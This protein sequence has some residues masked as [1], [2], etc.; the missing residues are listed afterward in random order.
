MTYRY[1]TTRGRTWLFALLLPFCFLVN[2]LSAQTPHITSFSPT[3]GTTGSIVQIHG[4]AFTGVDAVTFGK[5]IAGSFIVHSDT[6]ITAHVGGGNSGYVAVYSPK[7]YDSLAGFVFVSRADRPHILSFTPDSGRTGTVV[8][9]TGTHFTGTTAVRFGVTT[10]AAFTVIADT[11]IEATVGR[12]SSGVVTVT[13]PVATAFL[14]GFRYIATTV[15]THISFFSPTSGTMGTTVQIHGV[16]FTGTTFVGF[17][18]V[19]A[20]SFTVAAD[21]L[22]SAVVGGGASGAVVVSGARGTDS[23]A[24]FTYTLPVSDT[25][26][27]ISFTPDSGSRGTVVTINGIHFIGATSV[28]FGG[29]PATSFTVISDSVVDATVGL[30]ASGFVTVAN[31]AGNDSLAGFT[32]TPPAAPTHINYFNPT[33][34]TTGTTVFIHGV[35]FTGTTF[36]GFGGVSA[37]SFTVT[38]D[39]LIS[40]VVGGGASG[41]VVVSGSRGSDSLAGF[42]YTP[43]VSDT[44][45]I[46]SFT[47]D[48]GTTGT[49]VTINGTHF[50]GVSAVSFGGT[51]ASSFTVISD[52]V[53]DATVGNGSSG[54]VAMANSAGSDSLAGFVFVDSTGSTDS[55]PSA[56][57]LL[58][59]EYP[60]PAMGV[61]YVTVPN[62]TASSKLM[63]TDMNGRVV[64][65]IYVAPNATTMRVNVSGLVK[66]VYKLVWSD[67]KHLANQTVLVLNE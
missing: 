8:T 43:P 58:L 41:A 47:P 55:T 1:S 17:G 16:S 42:T 67:G 32:F 21:T 27:I 61:L 12:G 46:L 23:L 40:A 65:T 51:L 44:P 33:S 26:H 66:G 29:T 10:A 57:A 31:A 64:R 28:S 59:K 56:H 24:G 54:F 20:S 14:A 34:G 19:S 13:N 30:G 63:L 2:S 15:P 50:T 9:I 5:V 6:L 45:H 37:S 60:N 52:S 35:S 4:S 39:T 18:G 53:L 38:A 49:K 7:G 11:V 36:V 25:P 22:I 62:T 48:S 3:S